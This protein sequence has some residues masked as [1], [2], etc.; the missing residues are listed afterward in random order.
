MNKQNKRTLSL[1]LL[2]CLLLSTLSLTAFAQGESTEM[3][4]QIQSYIDTGFPAEY[5]KKL[6]TLHFLHPNW[7]F[8]PLRITDLRETYT[9]DYV[10]KMETQNPKTNLVSAGDAYTAYRHETNTE[11]Y[12]SGWYQA[13]AATVAYFMDPRNFLNEKDIFQFQNLQY[14]GNTVTPDMIET[15]LSG[16]FMAD[17]KL[18]NGMTYA[19]YFVSLGEELGV[20][21]IHLAARVR[22]EQGVKAGV[23]VSG[24]CGDRLAYY[25]ENNIQEEN[26]KLIKAPSSGY[27]KDDLLAYNGYY[28]YFNI[29][30]AGTG[31]FQIYLGAMKEA[32]KGTAAM[33][34]T[35]GGSASWDTRWK[36]LYGGAFRIREKYIDDYQNTLYLQKFNVD[37]RSKRNFWGQY[38]QNISGAFSEARTFYTSLVSSDCLDLPFNFLI[39][40]Y[41]DM[42]QTACAD[43]A[44]GTCATFAAADSGFSTLSGLRSPQR[45]EGSPDTPYCATLTD[46]VTAGEALTIEGFSVSTS[47]LGDFAYA[48]DGGAWQETE[49]E[50]NPEICTAY[51]ENYRPSTLGSSKNAYTVTL[52]TDQLSAGTHTLAIRATVSGRSNSVRYYLAALLTFTVTEAPQTT[53]SETETEAETGAPSPDSGTQTTQETATRKEPD[54]PAPGTDLTATDTAVTEQSDTAR[55]DTVTADTDRTGGCGS[56][57]SLSLF[58]AMLAFAILLRRKEQQA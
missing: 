14:S 49:S 8:T 37:P 11:R 41:D 15:A 16:T 43:P 47:A 52:Q 32:Q 39:P 3:D 31:Y 21:P 23:L 34:E 40:V 29:G 24:A 17:T 10:Q 12:D 2:L 51:R 58:P 56:V 9:W 46:P 19:E 50:K 45:T 48:V 6:A 20:D 4:Q 7:T 42:P 53:E 18:E 57:I 55:T 1:V 44:G 22:Q 54:T 25:Y 27:T 36:A 28:N 13:S 30:A 35:W 33:K 5:A 26:G 38:M